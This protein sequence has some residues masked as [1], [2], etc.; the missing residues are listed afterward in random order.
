[1]YEKMFQINSIFLREQFYPAKVSRLPLLPGSR[2][3]GNF[4]ILNGN[5]YFLLQIRILRSKT[6]QFCINLCFSFRFLIDGAAFGEN[7]LTFVFFEGNPHV[8]LHNDLTLKKANF[9]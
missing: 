8:L 5:S 3:G 2:A 4:E 1:M 7:W 9:V 6:R